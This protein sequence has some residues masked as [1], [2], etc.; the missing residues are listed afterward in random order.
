MVWIVVVIIGLISVFVLGVMAAYVYV[1]TEEYTKQ[2]ILEAQINTL[3]G[4]GLPP[5]VLEVWLHSAQYGDRAVLLNSID[6]DRN[7]DALAMVA[8]GVRTF[9]EDGLKGILTRR[10]VGMLRHEL[11]A[12]EL[13]TWHPS[14]RSQG[15]IW[16]D[17]GQALLE[18]C[19]NESARTHAHTPPTAKRHPHR[20]VGEGSYA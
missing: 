3:R 4:R 18:K 19:Q 16:T 9:S 13:C 7:I 8:S 17:E 5:R 11:M 12:R 15:V 1:S 2:Q 14:G 20:G 6:A 10:E